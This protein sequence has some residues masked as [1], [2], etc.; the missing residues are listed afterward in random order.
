MK[1]NNPPD[2]R[3]VYLAL[4][5]VF[6][7]ENA[8]VRQLKAVRKLVAKSQNDADVSDI[9]K[10]HN[11]EIVCN[12]ARTLLT[13]EVFESTLKA[14][15]RFPEVFDVSPAQSAE[16]EAS[17]AEA[18]ISE[19]NAIKGAVQ[20]YAD[21]VQD[22]ISRC[23]VVETESVETYHEPK[24]PTVK[25]THAVPSLFPTYLPLR[26]QH[27]ILTKVQSILEDACFDFGQ[28]VMPE[29]L[30]KNQ[31][32]CS[33]AAEL[34]LWAAEFLQAQGKFDKSVDVGMPLTKLFR[35]VADIRHTAVHRICISAKGLEHFLLNAESLA[36]LLGDAARLKSLADLR[37]TIQQ[38]IEELEGNKHV[39]SSKLTE[40]LKRIAA[41]RAELDRAEEAAIADMMR[42]DGEY[43][44]FAG[45][46][47]EEVAVF[48]EVHTLVG[49][50]RK[51]ETSSNADDADTMDYD[52]SRS[53]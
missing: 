29:V 46:N 40:T 15:I 21:E 23:D 26:T 6:K 4:K 37:R 13:E 12:T 18:A 24:R 5:N 9:I 34:N 32:V 51:D 35:S 22:P 16:R 19:A 42:E 1:N 7:G 39:L 10:A 44:A 52:S 45:K 49:S 48:S 17:E 53:S 27:R 43:Q 11:L 41:Q 31:W 38:A 30:K 20:R 3:V 33:E 36:L 2:E 47:L 8:K 28:R 14:K 25:S 50:S